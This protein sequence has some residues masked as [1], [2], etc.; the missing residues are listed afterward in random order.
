M[1]IFGSYA[2]VIADTHPQLVQRKQPNFG[3][4]LMCMCGLHYWTSRLNMGADPNEFVNAKDAPDTETVVERFFMF[5][6]P[7]CEYCPKQLRPMK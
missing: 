4:R 6:A 3:Q 2:N 7:I 1:S 5:A